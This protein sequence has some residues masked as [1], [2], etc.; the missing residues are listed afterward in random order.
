MR[1]NVP[2]PGATDAAEYETT[3]N[4]F[5]TVDLTRLVVAGDLDAESARELAGTFQEAV[6]AGN[7]VH[8][9]TRNLGFVDS[10]GLA[11]LARLAGS[12]PVSLIGPPEN[13]RFLL[14]LTH[15]GERV[16]VLDTDPGFP[17][18]AA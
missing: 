7:P 2:P 10:S 18:S 6:L 15:L 12:V 5:L 13:L 17:L 4:L 14:D 9:D 11:L 3:A 16:H 1:T 8:V